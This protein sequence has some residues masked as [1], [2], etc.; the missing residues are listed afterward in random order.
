MRRFLLATLLAIPP[1][2]SG[3]MANETTTP[4][5]YEHPKWK[6]RAILPAEDAL[7]GDFWPAPPPA[8]DVSFEDPEFA[9]SRLAPAPPPGV[10]PRVMLTPTDVEEIQKKIALGDKAPASF[11]GLWE[12]FKNDPTPFNALVTGNATLGRQLADGLMEKVRSLEKKMPRIEEQVDR[13][14]IWNLE[15]SMVA[16]GDPDQPTEI[17]ALADY[18]YLHKWMTPAE[19]EQTEKL[20]VRITNGRIS[21]YLTYP[22]HFL[23]NNHSGFGMDYLRLVL[24]VEGRPDVDP[25][26]R[27]L[28]IRK[29]KAML[30]WYLSPDGMCYES[31]KGWMNTSMYVALARRN[32]DLLKHSRWRSKMNFFEHAAHWENGRWQI[33][34]EMR[35]SAFPVIWMMRYFHPENRGYDWLHSA[36][37]TTH[38]F[39]LDPK[40]RWPA[41]VGISNELLLLFA[42]DGLRDK[43]GKPLD[44]TNQALIDSLK[45]PLTWKDD[46]RG[47]MITRNSWEKDDIQLGFTQKQDFYYGGHE[48]S[49]NNRF[50]L[51]ADGIN[52]GRD[53]DMLAVKATFLQNMLTIDGK[54]VDWPPVP[55]VWLG[56]EETPAGVIAAGDGKMGYSYA[57]V[58]QVHPLDFPSAQTGYYRPF[59]EGNFDLTRDHQVAFHPGTVKWNDGYAHTDYGP[60]SG[61]TR[62]VEDYRVFNPVE[63][64]YRTVYLARGKNPY[65]LI[66]DDAKKDDQEHLYE[67]NMTTPEGIDLLDTRTAEILFQS[68]PPGGG[69][70][71]DLLL[72]KAST[73]R[74]PKTNRA[75]ITKGDPLLLVRTLWRNSPY[76]FPA[77]SYRKLHVE[78]QAAYTGLGLVTV[79]AISKSPEFR[80]LLYPHRQGDPMPVT[81]WNDDRT[82]LTVTIGDVTDTYR[83]HSSEGGRTVFSVSRN[84][85]EVARSEARPAAPVLTVRGSEFNP[86]DLRTTRREGEIPSFPFDGSVTAVLERPVPPAFIAYTLDGSEPSA[87]SPRYE[88]PL[89][90]DAKTRLN[91]RLIDPGWTAGPVEGALL[92]ADFVPVAAAK[93]T[94]EPPAGTV[95]GLLAR[96]YQ[97]KTVKWDDKGFFDADKVMLPDLGRETPLISALTPG[98]VLPF[99]APTRPTPE[100]AK[101]FF[102]FSGWFHAE[103][104]GVYRFAINSCGPVVLTVGGQT[105]VSSKGVFHQ[106]QAIRSG[107][108]VLGAGWHTLDLVV[109][110][111]LFWNITTLDEMPFA[112]SVSRD[113]G[114][115]APVPVA[116]L[117]G[118]NSE[119]K[120]A[121]RPE[122]VWLEAGSPPAWLEPG[123]LLATYGREGMLR[124]PSFLDVDKETPVRVQ[125][126]DRFDTNIRPGLVRS[127]NGWFFAPED[128]IYRFDMPARSTSREHLSDLRGAYQNQLRVGDQVVVQRGVAGR[129]TTGEIGLKKGWHS[130]SIRLG[131]SEAEGTVTYPDGQTLPLTA[132]S[133][134]RE[135][136]LSIRPATAGKDSS[137]VEIYGPTDFSVNLP[138][139]RSGTVRYTL[140]GSEPTAASPVADGK[141]RLDRSAVVTAAVFPPEGA[142]QARTRVDVRLVDSPRE[143]LIASAR[144]DG[145]DGKT[146]RTTL[147]EQSL[148]WINP[149]GRPEKNPPALSVHRLDGGASLASGLDRNV[150]RGPNLAGVAISKMLMRE[151]A[152]TVGVWFKSDTVDGQIFG[153]DGLTPF[154][155]SYRTAS[156]RLGKGTLQVAA[157]R[158]TRVSAK[159]RLEPGVWNHVVVAADE[160]ETRVYLNG[161]E[162][163]RTEGSDTLSTDSFDFFSGHPGSIGEIRVFNRVLSPEDVS[164]WFRSLGS[165]GN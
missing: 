10:F 135:S 159:E 29:A 140:D 27:D 105:A 81:K 5:F 69:R 92:K 120:D 14:N 149:S 25:R 15:R 62:L 78:P 148:V 24:L 139:G 19:R 41:P 147:D 86:A 141:L 3:Q 161:R 61:E 142:P 82:E 63:K 56:V 12:R 163:A 58:M 43:D 40:E 6:P 37:F 101:G 146:G 46:Q 110:D 18:D 153:K 76:G 157:S 130:V 38:P 84:G 22:E 73:P 116:A 52:W 1:A 83:F 64:A 9:A 156:A 134:S 11:R 34:E 77:P 60:W 137:V 126:A 87:K 55:G 150:Y 118:T 143:G 102:R 89:R 32:P 107:E 39:L 79:P 50:A 70:E 4:E 91:A 123:T 57:K 28:S 115:S 128:G 158:S 17:W 100:Q 97:V 164:Q 68:V 26:V 151:N 59:A 108:A 138:K 51:W 160:T 113:G 103:Q 90:I 54:G 127:Y 96:V 136:K 162:V 31:I 75:T 67:W 21:N 131:A 16:A 165:A 35:A 47:Y 2:A 122:I 124:E 7:K 106:N 65:V 85:E 74:D 112:V 119:A 133:L 95:P 8:V 42:E 144:F 93:G 36:T 111:P 94:S 30:T 114:E 98:F 145:W 13:D 109:T 125:Q 20:I 53:S 72:G 49:E 132:A 129:R 66:L 44:W 23:I 155:K 117:R 152:M 45:L 71:T 99:A 48:G 80:I 154:G 104:P 88:K 121:A 33:R